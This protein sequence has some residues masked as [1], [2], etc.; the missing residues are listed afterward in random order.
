M[1]RMK[2]SLFKLLSLMLIGL[3]QFYRAVFSS[4]TP[5]NCR[6]EPTCSCYSIEALKNH[7]A[8]RGSWLTVRRIVRCNPWGGWGYDPVPPV[9]SAKDAPKYK[10]KVQEPHNV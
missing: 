8:L 1:I 9:N 6:F 10:M 3:V 2:D 7:G 4:I 5:G